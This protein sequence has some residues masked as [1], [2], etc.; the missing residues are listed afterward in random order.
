MAM[1]PFFYFL[2]NLSAY[3]YVRIPLTY[4]AFDS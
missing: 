2:S 4:K 3:A 1:L